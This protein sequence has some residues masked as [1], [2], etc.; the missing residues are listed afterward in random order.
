MLV[1]VV[2]T[3]LTT[4]TAGQVV[5]AVP[6]YIS[7]VPIEDAA[8]RLVQPVAMTEDANGIRVRIVEDLIVDDT[9]DN[10][11]SPLFGDLDI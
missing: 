2:A 8:G 6:V 9:A 4:D 7:A 11:V 3:E 1:H 5:A 10:P